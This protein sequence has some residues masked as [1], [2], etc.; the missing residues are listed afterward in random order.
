MQCSLCDFSGAISE[1]GSG[2]DITWKVAIQ[3]IQLSPVTGIGIGTYSHI[4]YQMFHS[5]N[6]AHNTFLQLSAEWGIPLAF[7]L[8]IYMFFTIGKATNF[9][10][11]NDSEM[12]LILRDIIIILLI[13]S[14]AISLNNAR[15]LWLILGA[16]VFSLKGKGCNM[17]VGK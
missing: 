7:M 8:F 12:N 17:Y 16:L 11:S 15:V 9:S 3:V 2:R 4:A 5:N 10:I 6:I 1:N 14:M 13:G